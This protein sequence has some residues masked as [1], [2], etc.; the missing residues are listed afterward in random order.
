MWFSIWIFEN[1]FLQ[2]SLGREKWLVSVDGG[3]KENILNDN[4][5]FQRMEMSRG[6]F[7]GWNL[8]EIS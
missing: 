7:G 3:K 4:S 2:L 6:R 8:R 5:T 1:L